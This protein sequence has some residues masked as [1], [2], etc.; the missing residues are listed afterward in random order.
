MPVSAFHRQETE[1]GSSAGPPASRGDARG[2]LQSLPVQSRLGRALAGEG[3]LCLSGCG[4]LCQAW[5]WALSERVIFSLL[6][7]WN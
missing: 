6:G 5:T 2:S 1:A 7:I 4:W 3:R